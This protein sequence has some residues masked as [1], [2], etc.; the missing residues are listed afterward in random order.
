MRAFLSCLKSEWSERKFNF[1]C[2]AY[3]MIILLFILNISTWKVSLFF[4]TSTLMYKSV[5]Y[6]ET[7]AL[8][9]I[10][11]IWFYKSHC[12][13]AWLVVPNDNLITRVS[14][15]RENTICFLVN[16]CVWFLFVEFCVLNYLYDMHKLSK[17]D[18]YKDLRR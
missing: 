4:Q 14:W 15:G 10:R 16:E 18:S 6:T 17:I 3:N 12:Y 7:F 5:F 1:C 13:C 9:Y 2:S 8:I 11:K